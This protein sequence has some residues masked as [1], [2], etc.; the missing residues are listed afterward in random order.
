MF[1]EFPRHE[2]RLLAL[3]SHF[4]FMIMTLAFSL[5]TDSNPGDGGQHGYVMHPIR[6]SLICYGVLS[7]YF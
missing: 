4:D 5:H 1:K 2:T 6:H 3:L 7:R